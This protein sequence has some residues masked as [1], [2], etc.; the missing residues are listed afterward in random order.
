MFLLFSGLGNKRKTAVYEKM[1]FSVR[2]VLE[3][4]AEVKRVAILETRQIKDVLKFLSTG[5][6]LVLEIYDQED[7]HLFDLSQNEFS[8]LFL[9]A[10]SP[11]VTF[12]ELQ[13]NPF[14]AR[15]RAKTE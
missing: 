11:Y 13:K 4:G 2:R 7:R 5:N 12:Q 14:F 10:K 6:Y 8:Q 3:K 9:L 15:K 1:D